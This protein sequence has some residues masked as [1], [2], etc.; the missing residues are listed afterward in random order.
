MYF[1]FQFEPV[2]GPTKGGT[3]LTVYGENFGANHSSVTA[4]VKIAQVPCDVV[5]R[6]HTR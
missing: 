4:I 5:R 3:L 1:V 2:D 6:E